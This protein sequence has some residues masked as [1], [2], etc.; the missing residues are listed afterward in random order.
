MSNLVV[1]MLFKKRQE[2]F[3]ELKDHQK[4]IGDQIMEINQSL[5]KVTGKK[6]EEIREMGEQYDDLNSDYIKNTED[7]I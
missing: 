1:E 3:E 7:G 2:L 6:W 4:R 5:L